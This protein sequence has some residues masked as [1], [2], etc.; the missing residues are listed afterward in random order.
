M[1]VLILDILI[2]AMWAFIGSIHLSGREPIS[3]STYGLAWGMLMLCLFLN[4]LN[5]AAAA[6]MG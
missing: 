4:I 2:W 5:S 6:M 3:K 1:G